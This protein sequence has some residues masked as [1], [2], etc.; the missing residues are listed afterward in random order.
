MYYCNSCR[1]TRL[2]LGGGVGSIECSLVISYYYYYY[3]FFTP[4][5]K[6]PGG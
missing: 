1:H 4:G 5:S 3:Y 6:D 2:I